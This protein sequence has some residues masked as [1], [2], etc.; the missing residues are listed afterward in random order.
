MDI[1]F[2][3]TMSIIIGVLCLFCLIRAIFKSVQHKLDNYIYENFDMTE[4]IGATTKA[5]FFGVKSRGSK[6]LRGNGAIVLTKDQLFFIRAVPFKEYMIYTKS[7]QRVS[8]PSSFNG[9]S[10]FS[11]LLCVHFTNDGIE[12][13][14]AW[15]I[16]NPEKWKASI[17]ALM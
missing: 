4:I 11:K 13:S 8:L 3:I 7:I 5:N 6:Q 2:T 16:K 14:I 15:A 12:D 17:E 9:K 1:K 10:V